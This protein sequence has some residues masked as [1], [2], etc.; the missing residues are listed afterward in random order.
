VGLRRSIHDYDEA[1][2]LEQYKAMTAGIARPLTDLP[3][4]S[5]TDARRSTDALA[6]QVVTETLGYIHERTKPVDN[7]SIYPDCGT[8]QAQRRHQFH[9]TTT[10]GPCLEARAEVAARKRE[11]RRNPGEPKDAA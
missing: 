1:I 5:W 9:R 7:L 3:T 11:R 6:S 8:P 4:G 10:C 2:T